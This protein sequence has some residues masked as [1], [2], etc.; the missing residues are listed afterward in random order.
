MK[1]S[2]TIDIHSTLD[3]VWYWLGNPER[4]MVWQTNISKTEILQETPDVIGTTF[5]E[6]ITEGGSSV[7]MQGM[8]T[9][10]IEGRLIAMHLSG[11]YNVVDVEWRLEELG[12]HTRLTQ[13][14]DIRFRSLLKV[15][16]VLLRPVF[17]KKIM[18]QLQREC[19]RL[20]EIC[21]IDS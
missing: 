19:A 4:A 14:S 7:E 20:K 9:G 3:K 17:K 5:R 1:V 6:T 11:K 8:V 2:Y 12:A 13:N 21:E 10:F 16:S 15:L 18:T